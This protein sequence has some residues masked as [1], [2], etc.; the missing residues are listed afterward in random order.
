MVGMEFS[1]KEPYGEGGYF[2][3]QFCKDNAVSAQYIACIFSCDAI[4]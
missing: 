4:F 2:D 1:S 3:A